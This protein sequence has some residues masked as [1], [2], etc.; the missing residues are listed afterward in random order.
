MALS[1]AALAEPSPSASSRLLARGE[2]ILEQKCVSHNLFWFCID[3]IEISLR[4]DRWSEARRYADLLEVGTGD[5]PL[6]WTDL[7]IESGRVLARFGAGERTDSLGS[8]LRD[9]ELRAGAAHCERLREALQPA[10]SRFDG[11]T[12]SHQPRFES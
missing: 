8:S 1:A 2:A 12:R 7:H 5:E 3:A 10:L 11:G 6:P 9:L 4:N